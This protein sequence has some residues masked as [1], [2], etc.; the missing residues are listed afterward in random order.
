MAG[1]FEVYVKTYFSATRGSGV[2]VEV[3]LYGVAIRV[4][5]SKELKETFTAAKEFFKN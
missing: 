1:V 4:A 5:S 2:C 3:R